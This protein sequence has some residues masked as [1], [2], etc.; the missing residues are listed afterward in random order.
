MSVDALL[1]AAWGGWI[2]CARVCPLPLVVSPIDAQAIHVPVLFVI[3]SRDN[4]FCTPPEC[5]EAQLESSLYPA[6]AQVEVGVLPG[7]GHSLNL[8]FTAP[9]FFGIA[10]EWSDRHFGN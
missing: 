1:C 3:G 6:D 4:V 8:H 7:T 2:V 9:V 10:R 5:P